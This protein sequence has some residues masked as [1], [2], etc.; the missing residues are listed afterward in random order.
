[1]IE[2]IER[3]VKEQ[4]I[5]GISSETKAMKTSKKDNED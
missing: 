5:E 3:I 4:K 2:L 1:M